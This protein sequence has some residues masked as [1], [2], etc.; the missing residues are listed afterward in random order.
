MVSTTSN[1][2]IP[3]RNN[4]KKRKKKGGCYHCGSLNHRGREC[5]D[6]QCQKCGQ[7]GHDAGSC[8]QRRRVVDLGSF[9]TTKT[10]T[11]KGT[12]HVQQQQQQQQQQ[13][14][15]KGDDSTSS[16]TYVE[17]FAGIGGFRVAL[18]RLGGQCVF[19]SE[20]NK[21]ACRNY[22][23]NFHGDRPAGDITNIPSTSIPSQFDLLVG[24]FPCQ[25]FSSS[26][27]TRQGLQDEQGRGVLFLEI[28]RVLKDKQPSMFLLENVRGLLT[29]DDGKTLDIIV[30]TLTHCGYHVVHSLVN[31]V[32][33]LPQERNRLYLVGTLI[34]S[35]ESPPQKYKFPPFP[36]LHRGVQDILQRRRPPPPKD[37]AAV[38]TTD[39][40]NSL[41]QL[42]LSDH[43]LKKVKSQPYTQKFPEARFLQNTNL[44][45]KTLQSSYASYMV[46]S[47]FVKYLPE[48]TSLS[49]NYSRT[50]DDDNKDET[51]ITTKSENHEN[52]NNSSSS[53]KKKICD[54]STTTTPPTH[55][56]SS[57]IT[58]STTTPT[59]WRKFSSREAARLQGFPETFLLCQERPY[60]LLGN[61]VA[62]PVIALL[63]APLL[64]CSK[65][66]NAVVP[67]EFRTTSTQREESS[68]L[69]SLDSPPPLQDPHQVAWN[70]GWS[71]CQ[72]LLLEASPNDQRRLDLKALLPTYSMPSSL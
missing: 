7:Q 3:S 9:G 64:V 43:Q 66:I 65:G 20:I 40:F 36:N 71:V 22:E 23:L 39:K 28:A 44:P 53:K 42:C 49:S 16:F 50:K 38:T 55:T 34:S 10:P 57:T 61:A 59:R 14:H 60:H 29:H 6:V 35:T 21:F 54:P 58:S 4:K 30:Q 47:Q 26:S 19:A 2:D 52:H 48:T 13:H 72:E 15:T 69:L 1:I 45:S 67:P 24:G 31:A 51:G 17:L 63:A 12:T 62:P 41:E 33:I 68:S 11:G 18:D 56:T 32:H 46:G 70:W 27:S 8:P 37:N 25:P 5:P